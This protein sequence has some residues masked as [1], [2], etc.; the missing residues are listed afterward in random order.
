MAYWALASNNANDPNKYLVPSLVAHIWILE[1]N[2][3]IRFSEFHRRLIFVSETMQK[4]TALVEKGFNSHFSMSA[5]FLWKT[6]INMRMNANLDA[7]NLLWNMMISKLFLIFILECYF[8]EA[9][10]GRPWSWRA[11]LK[12]WVN[13]LFSRTKISIPNSL[14]WIEYLSCREG[15]R[16]TIT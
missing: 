15:T 7:S 12:S 2:F 5:L 13:I 11:A 8:V 3:L 16:D 14:L 9:S 4:A 1:W 6:N 10:P